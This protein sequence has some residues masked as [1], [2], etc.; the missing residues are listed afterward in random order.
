M[1]VGMLENDSTS[2]KDMLSSDLY[3][4]VSIDHCGFCK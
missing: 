4:S 1:K 3:M 2:C